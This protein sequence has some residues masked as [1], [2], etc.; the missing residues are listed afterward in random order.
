MCCMCLAPSSNHVK[1]ALLITHG[2]NHPSVQICFSFLCSR[3]CRQL[4][5]ECFISKPFQTFSGFR[6]AA[7]KV[8]CIPV[9]LQ[10]TEEELGTQ[11]LW[12]LPWD[13]QS[14]MVSK[15]WQFTL[16][17]MMAVIELRRSPVF[18]PEVPLTAD[19]FHTKKNPKIKYKCFIFLGLWVLQ[20]N[21]QRIN[22]HS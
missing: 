1:M 11:E 22:K 12:I 17:R 4:L 14:C 10:E 18:W 6:S 21:Y 3:N 13:C 16:A 2:M 7:R 20:G 15:C 19:N 8:C 5:V 9:V